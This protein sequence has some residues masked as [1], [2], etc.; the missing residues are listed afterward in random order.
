MPQPLSVTLRRNADDLWRA[1]IAHP[2]IRGIVDG[3]LDPE[4][5]SHYIRQDYLFLIDYGRLLALASARSPRLDW[6]RR[7]AEI[8]LETLADEMDLH[9]AYAAEWGIAPDELTVVS[10]TATTCAYTDFLLRTAALGSYAELV[11]ALL[12]CVWGYSWLGREIAA[13]PPV[14]GS[15]YRSWITMYASEDFA[16]LAA[17][18]REVFDNVT[19]GLPDEALPGVRDVFI[20]ASRHELAF[21]D[22]SWHLEPAVVTSAV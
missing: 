2:F 18:C 3:S 19:A 9:R 15:P 8:A 5:F 17:W 11:G 10:P 4:R 21:W 1:Q 20:A 22:A 7:F 16:V 12:P 14:E 6:Q 13:E